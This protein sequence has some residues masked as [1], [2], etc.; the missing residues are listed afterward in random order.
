[1]QLDVCLSSLGGISLWLASVVFS[2]SPSVLSIRMSPMSL[3]RVLAGLLMVSGLESFIDVKENRRSCRRSGHC[4]LCCIV[5]HESGDRCSS[6]ATLQR[7]F[8]HRTRW[9]SSCRF[10]ELHWDCTLSATG[11]SLLDLLFIYF[12]VPESLPERFRSDQR[13]SWNKIDP[14]SVRDPLF[15]EL[16]SLCKLPEWL[17]IEKHHARSFHLLGLF[18]RFLVVSSGWVRERNSWPLTTSLILTEAGQYSCFFVYLRLVSLLWIDP[19]RSAFLLLQMLG[20]SEDEVAYFIAFIGILSCIAQVCSVGFL[21]R[22]TD[23][24]SL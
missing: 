5:D 3:M 22:P 17:G 18:D 12:V 6:S 15:D 21:H 23:V 2:P 7:E 24:R 9:V 11:V 16:P 13:I 14:F 10:F 1:M 19:C 8:Y 20:F 4:H